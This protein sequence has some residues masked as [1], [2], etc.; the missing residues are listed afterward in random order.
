MRK[1]A[2]LAIGAIFIIYLVLAHQNQTL[3]TVPEYEEKTL[4]I[5]GDISPKQWNEERSGAIK[6][7]RLTELNARQ[8]LLAEPVS[9]GGQTWP[10]HT[11][12][13]NADYTDLVAAGRPE[14]PVL[15]TAEVRSMADLRLRVRNDITDDSGSVV[16][17][18]GTLL[19]RDAIEVLMDN[20][21]KRIGVV[22]EGQVVGFNATAI[23]VIIIFIGMA[24]VLEMIFWQPMMDFLD[25]RNR[26]LREGTQAMRD[27][28][29]EVDNIEAA[30][31]EGLREVHQEFQQRL[32]KARRESMSEADKITQ[33]GLAEI[34]STRDRLMEAMRVEVKKAD[35]A[36]AADVPEIA[37]EI[38]DMVVG[39]R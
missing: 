20:D 2:V 17:G 33:K 3:Y 11:E 25:K 29:V 22:G 15:D 35:D 1:I 30:R 27:N 21:I 6:Q 12:L 32:T 26:E 14:V 5:Y 8:Y 4:N 36:L 24:L 18:A 34:R 7:D 16:L 31:Q 37:R 10:A 38:R 19:D 28:R 23:M 13:R 9:A 39:S